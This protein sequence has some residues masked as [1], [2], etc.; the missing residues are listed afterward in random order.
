MT[1]ETGRGELQ[2]VKDLLADPAGRIRLYDHCMA[3]VTD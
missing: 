3:Q 1:V 2:F